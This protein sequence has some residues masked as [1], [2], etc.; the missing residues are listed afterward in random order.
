LFVPALLSLMLLAVGA[1][2]GLVPVALAVE[3]QQGVKVTMNSYYTDGTATFPSFFDTASGDHRTVLPVTLRNLRV[4]GVCVSTK[5]DTPVGDYVV[6]ITSPQHGGIIR[7]GDT[8]LALDNISSLDFAGD[9]VGINYGAK[10]ADGTPTDSGIPGY[11]PIQV[12][13]VRL[14]LNLTIRWLTAN[15]IH[16]NGLTL[17]GGLNQHECY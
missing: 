2:T 1:V 9:S 10:T 7:A 8:T 13:G 14:G 16:L 15:Q 17:A 11:V 4:Q 5:V 6:R 12:N 3:G